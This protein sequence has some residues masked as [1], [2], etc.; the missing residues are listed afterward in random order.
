MS[1]AFRVMFVCLLPHT[2]Y[3]STA[4]VLYAWPQFARILLSSLV[5]MANQ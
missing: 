2:Y 1:V 4:V 3:A 5:S